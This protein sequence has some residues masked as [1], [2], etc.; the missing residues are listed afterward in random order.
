MTRD[1]STRGHRGSRQN[2]ALLVV[3]AVALALATQQALA[4]RGARDEAR[5]RLERART[6][7]AS[8]R[9]QLGRAGGSGRS[10]GVGQRSLLAREA[11]PPRVLADVVA[12]LPQNVRLDGLALTYGSHVELDLQVVAR[13]A[14]EYD[15]FLERLTGSP[16][17]TGV[18]PGT[19]VREG[20]VRAAVRARYVAREDAS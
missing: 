5:S 2:V 18:L 4:A 6:D 12:L 3:G 16:L 7:V 13:R 15:L 17:F 20:E 14:A 19:E 1:F 8:L 11:P 9:D 10:A